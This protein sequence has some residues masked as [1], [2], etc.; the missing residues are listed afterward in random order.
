MP[1]PA[2]LVAATLA[3]LVTAC[4]GVI[5]VPGGQDRDKLTLYVHLRMAD[6]EIAAAAATQG[7]PEAFDELADVRADLQA[8]A[9]HLKEGIRTPAATAFASTLDQSVQAIERILRDRETLIAAS[10]TAN[11]V[12]VRVPRMSAQLAEIVRG[13]SDSGAPAAQL[14]LANRQIVLLERMTRRIDEIIRGGDAAVTAADA[15]QRDLTVFDQVLQGLDT[16]SPDA[17]IA[18]VEGSAARAAIANVIALNRDHVDDVNRFLAASRTL[19]DA[20]Q[21]VEELRA[22]RLIL[23]EAAPP[24]Y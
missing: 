6:A 13:M 3:L 12:V 15:L 8:V 22:N 11:T 2:L 21:G 18:R 9:P 4:T 23:Q 20:H 14:N 16:G 24:G 17:G 19:A 7:T 5:D 1:R 10:E